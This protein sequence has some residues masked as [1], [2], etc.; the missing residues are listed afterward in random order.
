MV[1][2]SGILSR[3]TYFVFSF[4]QYIGVVFLKRLLAKYS[5]VFKQLLEMLRQLL[6]R[7]KKG[8]D[9]EDKVVGIRFLLGLIYGCIAYSIYRFGAVPHYDV[10][11]LVWSLSI[12]VYILSIYIV[13]IV[14]KVKTFF[15]LFIR[16]IFTFFLSWIITAFVLFDLIG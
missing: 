9:V 14:V 13:Y 6:E 15:L 12:F 16:G 1:L 11:W 8:I 5:L 7:V 2:C 3:I 4:N 10:S